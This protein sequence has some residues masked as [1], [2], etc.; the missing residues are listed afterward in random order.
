MLTLIA[1]TPILEDLV[2][3]ATCGMVEVESVVGRG[4]DPHSFVLSPK[5]VKAL[6][7]A[8]AV[9]SLGAGLEHWLKPGMVR[10]DTA[11]LELAGQLSLLKKGARFDPHF[12]HSPKFV[13]EAGQKI[14][15]FVVGLP[16]AD[17]V[18]IESCRPTFEKRVNEAEAAARNVLAVVPAERRVIALTHDSMGYFG[19]AF[20]FRVEAL[21]GL[22]TEAS[23]TPQSVKRLV[24][25][26]KEKKIAAVFVETGTQRKLMDAVA[27]EAGVKVGG[28]LVADALGEKGTPAGTVLGMWQQNAKVIASALK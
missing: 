24:N 23:P 20:S 14:A 25:V 8:G 27:R 22:N 28:E 4:V 21:M 6:N 7:G 1:T 11:K 12:W 16:G 17:K 15:A 5:A 19:E 3:E 26:V 13:K 9:V 2:R 10:K 18:K